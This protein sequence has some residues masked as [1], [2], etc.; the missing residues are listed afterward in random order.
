[1]NIVEQKFEEIWKEEHTLVL[2]YRLDIAAKE[3]ERWTA[4]MNVHKVDS[5]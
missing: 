1:M 2:N 3:L 4:V 5:Q